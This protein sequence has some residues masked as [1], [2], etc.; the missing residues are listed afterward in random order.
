MAHLPFHDYKSQQVQIQHTTTTHLCAKQFIKGVSGLHHIVLSVIRC[1]FFHQALSA[2]FIK[3]PTHIW[4]PRLL[5]YY[6]SR[7]KKHFFLIY[8]KSV[9]SKVHNLNCLVFL[10]YNFKILDLIGHVSNIRILEAAYR[11]VILFKASKI[12]LSASGFERVKGH[13]DW[14]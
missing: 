5:P 8:L 3:N 2:I 1:Y 10:H 6:R 12:F 13:F 9:G 11:K 7:S 14:V 4:E